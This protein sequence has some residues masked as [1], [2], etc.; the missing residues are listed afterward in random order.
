M[1]KTLRSPSS[2][3]PPCCSSL[4]QTGSGQA[5]S[6]C[7][8]YVALLPPPAWTLGERWGLF[9]G[10]WGAVPSSS[11][12]HSGRRCSRLGV[13]WYLMWRGPVSSPDILSWVHCC[14]A[15][16]L[17]HSQSRSH[18]MALK[19]EAEE[20][21]REH[22]ARKKNKD[23]EK[24]EEKALKRGGGGERKSLTRR[25]RGKKW[26]RMGSRV[27]EWQASK[28]QERRAGTAR[29]EERRRKDLSFSIKKNSKH[30]LLPEAYSSWT[31][32]TGWEIREWE[33]D[34]HGRAVKYR[35]MKIPREKMGGGRK[36]WASSDVL[37][38]WEWQKTG[39]AGKRDR[40]QARRSWN[41]FKWYYSAP[42]FSAS[43]PAPP[44]FSSSTLSLAAFL[45]LSPSPWLLPLFCKALQESGGEY[46]TVARST[47]LLWVVTSLLFTNPS[48]FSAWI[49]F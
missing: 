1:S 5:L 23:S 9:L 15:P 46:A 38:G 6:W 48:P 14:T 2:F 41:Q 34:G 42:P 36:Q 16:I 28:G 47:S 35:G 4:R 11:S 31:V 17:H 25:K 43:P 24:R 27:P 21:E 10:A 33:R 44:P 40:M 22:M 12:H 26:D 29:M 37:L 49:I 7:I 20:G 18:Q 19:S 8:N 45:F 13:R 39:A 3:L 32:V 30:W